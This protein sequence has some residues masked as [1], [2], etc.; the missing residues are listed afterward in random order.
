VRGP[1]EAVLESLGV[2]M[3]KKKKARRPGRAASRAVA[4]GSQRQQPALP[5]A[6]DP[7]QDP[8]LEEGLMVSPVDRGWRRF[9]PPS[10]AT[11]L[12]RDR[13]VAEMFAEIP[14]D[15][16]MW[17]WSED[18]EP[19]STEDLVRDE[20]PHL[21]DDEVARVTAEW[22]AR[23]AAV[24]S[25][26]HRRFTALCDALGVAEP[27][28]TFTDLYRLCLQ[29]GIAEERT[30]DGVPWVFPATAARNVLDIL[31][32][33]SDLA[34][35]ER[36]A[37][38]QASGVR[39]W[40]TGSMLYGEYAG[41]VL[42]LFSR[43]AGCETVTT[44][45]ARVARLLDVPEAVARQALAHLTSVI[46][47]FRRSHMSCS[48][49]PLTVPAHRVITLTVDWAAH[50]IDKGFARSP[51][52]LAGLACVTC[53]ADYRAD[54]ARTAVVAGPAGADPQQ[55]PLVACAG[56]CAAECGSPSG[57]GQPV[58][59][60]EERVLLLQQAASAGS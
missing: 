53:G 36:A 12:E 57:T 44:S 41:Q 19:E 1:V 5:R 55:N 18:L 40:E 4:G 6:V 35:D 25:E 50:D 10:A 34:A 8:D 13:P 32:P 21:T 27:E 29:V 26:H 7:E 56:L 2:S 48:H 51:A 46:P 23:D 9:L 31:P 52:Q 20:Y 15:E 17:T 54:P 45:I 43:D 3:R 11:I 42:E 22:D 49:D 37:Q 39:L 60:L 38:E 14:A 30:C 47:G 24:R 59:P 16:P 33:A 28:G 58:P